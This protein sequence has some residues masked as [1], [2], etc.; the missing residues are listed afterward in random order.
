MKLNL[1]TIRVFPGIYIFNFSDRVKFHSMRIKLAKT[2]TPWVTKPYQWRKVVDKNTG[3]ARFVIT[4][5]SK[6]VAELAT[7]CNIMYLQEDLDFAGVEANPRKKTVKKHRRGSWAK[8]GT[9]CNGGYDWR[10]V[11]NVLRTLFIIAH[12][13]ESDEQFEKRWE[14]TD[15]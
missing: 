1:E 13:P 9:W 4:A 12:G 5:L 6:D 2:C 8:N 11:V 10:Q 14:P 7:K 3:K 15:K